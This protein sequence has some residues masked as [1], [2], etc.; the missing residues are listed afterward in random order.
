MNETSSHGLDL[1]DTNPLGGETVNISSMKDPQALRDRI[2]EL[3]LELPV[4]DKILTAEEG[5]PM[6][7]PMKVG[8][9]DVGNRWCAHPMEGWDGELDGSPTY[10]VL[11]RWERI[12]GSGAKLIWGEACA[13][14]MDGRANARQLTARKEDEAGLRLLMNTAKNAHEV[15]FGETDDL[16]IGLQLTHSG[17]FSRPHGK[18]IEPCIAYHHPLLDKKFGIDPNNDSVVLEDDDIKRLMDKYVE[19]AK[20][21]HRAGFQFV[22]KKACHGY[23]GHEFLSAHTRDGEFGGSFENRTRFLTETIGRIKDE[24]PELLIGVRLSVFDT[25][26]FIPGKERGGPMDYSDCL[27]YEYGFGVDKNDPTKIDLAEPIKLMQML[28]KMGVSIL[29]LTAGSPYY[30]YHIQRPTQLQPCDGYGSPEDPLIDVCRQINIAHQCKV[31]VPGIPMVGTAFTSL[32]KFTPHVAQALVHEGR[33]DS[34]GLGRQVLANP[35]MPADSLQNG[36]M[37]NALNCCGCSACTT[38]ARNGMISGCYSKDPYY[39]TR[40][41]A[42][43]VRELVGEAIKQ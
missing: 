42:R 16:L 25:P 36:T 28:E 24:C 31:A 33:I 37:N 19:S 8:D 10:D 18:D 35:N 41:E 13:V 17:R 7:Q 23:L 39:K 2:A 11:H 29:N 38:S 4:D 40:P 26:P 30:N 22:D 9:R 27:P 20:T 21:A 5:S 32:G 1:L 3:G 15:K 43:R 12:G 34:V 14:Q 6:A